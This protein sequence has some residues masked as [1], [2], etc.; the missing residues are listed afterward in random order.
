MFA[1]TLNGGLSN[2]LRKP[3]GER[4]EEGETK[5]DGK[6]DFSARSA[7]ASALENFAPHVFR[8]IG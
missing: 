2:V 7:R 5:L 4:Q 1:D 8:A 3:A 6:E